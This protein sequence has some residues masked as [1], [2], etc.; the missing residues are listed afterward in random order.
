MTSLGSSE[1][2][3]SRTNPN[4]NGSELN[5][6]QDACSSR[7]R[8]T[9]LGPFVGLKAIGVLLLAFVSLPIY[10]W[11]VYSG[12]VAVEGFARKGFPNQRTAIREGN[13]TNL[14]ATEGDRDYDVES[15]TLGTEYQ[16]MLSDMLFDGF[17][18]ASADVSHDL[19]KNRLQFRALESRLKVSKI[20]LAQ[21]GGEGEGEDEGLSEGS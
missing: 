1:L 19:D 7:P 13:L 16:D 11:G 6:A 10:A 3:C 2:F 14:N 20:I 17:D 8:R 9:S 12:P 18:Y 4:L 15:P 5:D 21:A